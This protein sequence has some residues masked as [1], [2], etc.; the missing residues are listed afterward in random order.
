M[1]SQINESKDDLF[2][3]LLLQKERKKDIKLSLPCIY[4]EK[5]PHLIQSGDSRHTP[6]L[7]AGSRAHE[8]ASRGSQNPVGDSGTRLAV[9]W[10]KTTKAEKGGGGTSNQPTHL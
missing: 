8:E 4:A 2:F 5:K 9:C 10:N 7:S 1:F 3:V 6:G